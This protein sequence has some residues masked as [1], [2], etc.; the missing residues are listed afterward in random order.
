MRRPRTLPSAT[1]PARIRRM[2]GACAAAQSIFAA[3]SGARPGSR[4]SLTS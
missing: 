3:P 4:R 1:M 2:T